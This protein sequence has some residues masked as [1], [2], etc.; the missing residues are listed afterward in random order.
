MSMFRIDRINDQLHGVPMLTIEEAEKL[1]LAY[2]QEY[3]QSFLAHWKEQAKALKEIDDKI[4]PLVMSKD[5][6]LD[7]YVSR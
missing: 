4:Y 5:G 6:W 3:V 2:V 7:A 1:L